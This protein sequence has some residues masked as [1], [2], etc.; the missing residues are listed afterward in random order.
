MTALLSTLITSKGSVE[1]DTVQH[2]GGTGSRLHL[3]HVNYA[4]QILKL[5]LDKWATSVNQLRLQTHKALMAHLNDPK[6]SIA[7]QYGALSAIIAL[8]PKV[9]E[10]CVLPQM[11]RYL[12]S[13][14][15][16]MNE[17]YQYSMSNGHHIQDGNGRNPGRE[18]VLMWGTFLSAARSI[19]HSAQSEQ[20]TKDNMHHVYQMMAR[21]FGDTVL[22]HIP[23][24]K[25]SETEVRADTES[26]G[27]RLRIRSLPGGNG[28]LTPPHSKR[29]HLGYA[30]P[31]E[32]DDIFDDGFDT[33][34][35]NGSLQHE[36]E[37]PLT[38]SDSVKDAFQCGNRS[39]VVQ[40]NPNIRFNV[41]S[42]SA[43]SEQR[44]K[45]KRLLGQEQSGHQQR[46]TFA[47]C[48]GKRLGH[49]SYKKRKKHFS[50]LSCS[51][52]SIVL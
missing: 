21:H 6:R 29:S 7:S 5:A 2:P 8:G 10:T 48:I 4:A 27:I 43:W 13:C 46:K 38:L 42:M 26:P 22:C 3:E 20:I 19:L 51:L 24:P 34:A 45:R 23:L 28:S 37:L 39:S 14:E 31:S 11:D 16:K 52:E 33:S 36:N 1:N 18:N 32:L 17:K 30:Y 15:T 35:H 44:L 50:L 12:S 47:G 9:L 49:A 40:V 41:R 25:M